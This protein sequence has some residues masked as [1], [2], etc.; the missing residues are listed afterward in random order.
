MQE[1]KLIATLR[2][3]VENG[4]EFVVVGGLA[5][6][7][8]GAPIQ[9]FDIDLVYSQEPTN[10]DRLL[11]VLQSLDAIFRIQPERRLRPTLSHLAGAGHLNLSTL[12]GPIDLLASIG[13][14]LNFRDL[15]SH[16]TEMDIGAGIFVR[17]LDLETLVLLKEQSGAEKDQA[18][19][20]ILR[21]TLSELRKKRGS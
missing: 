14:G 16:S 7:L 2:I 6:V 1:S 20:P 11:R 10:I 19:I 9:T 17:V 12:Y 13:Q 8:N 15:L 21:R 3:L 5:A 18:M 4:I